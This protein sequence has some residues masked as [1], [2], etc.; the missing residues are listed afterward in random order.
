MTQKHP[1]GH[2]KA[3]APK[4]R[5][6]WLPWLIGFLL[7]C[8]IGAMILPRYLSKITLFFADDSERLIYAVATDNIELTRELL[9]KMTNPDT[10]DLK[11]W[12]PLHFAAHEGYNQQA[13]MLLRAGASVN[14]KTDHG[15]TPL[16]WAIYQKHPETAA[17]L[18]RGNADIHAR[19]WLGNPPLHIAVFQEDYTMAKLLLDAGADVNLRNYS[20]STALDYAVHQQSSA[21]I[22]LLLSRNADPESTKA[23]SIIMLRDSFTPLARAAMFG[24]TAIALRLMSMNIAVS[25]QDN[26]GNTPLHEAAKYNHPQFV[27]LLLQFDAD[28]F[29]KNNKGESPLE[30]A[31]TPAIR[32]LICEQQ[33][34]RL[35][36][37]ASAQSTNFIGNSGTIRRD[38]L[39]AAK[40]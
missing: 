28:P 14:P 1:V 29:I 16:H 3:A 40:K 12:T 5:S 15:W 35:L 20:G 37:P 2:S 23:K 26:L 22:E 25:P 30:L 19:N 34:Q 8:I 18:L 32:R 24:N 17:I 38:S 9:Q 10:R 11:H 31:A 6:K 13:V 39:E 27:R 21:I 4:P 33:M 36:N 7:L